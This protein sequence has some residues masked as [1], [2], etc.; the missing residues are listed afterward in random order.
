MNGMDFECHYDDEE[1]YYEV[2]VNEEYGR[3][4]PDESLHPKVGDKFVIYGWDATKIG[5]TGLI[6]AAEE[7]LYQFIMKKLQELKI[8]PN[9]YNCSMKSD[10]YE[11]QMETNALKI[12]SLGQKVRLI[13]PTYFS[14]GRSSRIIGYEVKLDYIYDSPMYIVGE[15]L[16]YSRSK[17]I[18]EQI[19]A[20]TYNGS[21]YSGSGSGGSGVYIITNTSQTPASDYNVFSALRSLKEFVSKKKDDIAEGLLGLR[22]GVWFGSRFWHINGEGNARLNDVDANNLHVNNDARFD[23]G[24]TVGNFTGVSGG[25]LTIDEF[26][27]SYGE[28][29]RLKVRMKAYFESL[30]TQ[31]V[32]TVGGKV[33]ISPAGAATIAFVD[34]HRIV[35]VENEGGSEEVDNGIPEG[36][37][38]CYFIGEQDGVTL[39]NLWK[40]GDQ[41]MSKTFNISTGVH[42][43]VSNHYYWRLVTAISDESTMLERNGLKYHW[44]DL[45]KYDCDTGS[46]IPVAT[47]VVAQVGNRT[48][49]TRQNALIFSSVDIYSPSVTLCHGIDSYTFLNKEYVEYGVNKST[50]KAFFNVFGDF[51]TGD[52][53]DGNEKEYVKY[54]NGK[55][56]IAG[57]LRIGNKST[58]DGTPIDQYIKDNG[59]LTEEEVKTLIGKDIDKIQNQID[60]AI[61]TWFYSGEP[62]LINSPA[63]GW[64]NDDIKDVH[65][66]DLYY[67]KETGYGYR[68]MY[69]DTEDKYLWY[70]ITD[71]DIIKA[72]DNAAKAQGTADSKMKV[73]SRQPIDSESYDVGDLWVNATYPSDGS[74]YK[75]DIL[76][77]SVKKDAGVAFNIQHWGK[78]SKY[79]D[80]TKALQALNEI[81]ET[82]QS[83]G[84][85]E[86]GVN[87]FKTDFDN[88]AADGVFTSAEVAALQEDARYIETIFQGAKGS[89]DKVISNNLL[90]D[91]GKDSTEKI[92]LTTAYN[93]LQKAKTD[94]VNIIHNAVADYKADNF[95]ITAVSSRYNNFNDAYNSF[96][97]A[98]N[99]AERYITDKSITSTYEGLD[100]RLTKLAKNFD[101]EIQ[102]GLILSSMLALRGAD[103]KTINAGINGVQKTATDIATWWGGAMKDRQQPDNTFSQDGA[104]SLIRF[105]GSGYFANGAI[106]WN[107]IGQLH[108]DPLSFF[109]GDNYVGLNLALFQFVPNNATRIEDVSHVIPQAPFKSLNVIDYIAIGKIKLSWDA[110]NNALKIESTEDGGTANLYAT[111]GVSALGMS[112]G[113]TGGGAGASSLSELLDVSVGNQTHG[114]VLGWDG[115]GHWVPMTVQ[116]GLD[117][118]ALANYLSTNKYIKDGDNISRLNNNAGYITSSALSG[119]ATQSW[120]EEK[121]YLTAHQSIS[122]L[123]KIDGSNGT[124]EGL[125]AMINKLNI[126]DSIPVDNDYF[127]SQYVNGGTTT[128]TYYRRKISTLWSYIK[129]KSDAIYQPKGSYLTSHQA[130]DYINVKDIRN[131]D[132]LP[133]SFASRKLT[134]WFNN[135]NVPYIG[136]WWSGITVKGWESNYASWQLASNAVYNTNEKNLYFRTGINSEWNSWQKVLTSFNTKIEDGVI[137]ING[138]SITPLTSHQ[139]LANYV[140]RSTNQDIS[141]YKTFLNPTKHTKEMFFK[142]NGGNNGIYFHSLADGGL[143]IYAHTNYSWI[144]NLG[145][146]DW[147]GNIKMNSFIKSGGTAHQFLKAD[148]SVDSAAYIAPKFLFTKG[149]FQHYMVLLWKE[150][151]VNFHRINGKIYTQTN[152]AI[153][154]QAAN[155]DMWYSRW[156][157]GF[158]YNLRLDTFGLGIKWQLVTCTYNGE[159]WYA[160]R[161]ANTQAV[162]AYFVGTSYNINFTAIHYYTSN[163]ATVVNTEINSSIVDKTSLLSKPY[164]G[165]NA[166]ALVS[167]NVASASM[168]ANTRIIWGQNF[169]GTQNVTGNMTSVGD[170]TT[171]EA[172]GRKITCNG[173]DHTW[174]LYM[175]SGGENRG[176][177]EFTTGYDKWLLY[178]NN[179]NTILNHGNVGVGITPTEKLHVNGTIKTTS[180]KLAQYLF[181]HTTS[182]NDGTY[183]T[184]GSTG[185]NLNTHTGFSYTNNIMTWLNTGNVG[186]GNGAPSYKLDVNGDTIVR[187]W[188]RTTGQRGWYSQDYGGGWYMTDSTWLRNYGSKPLNIATGLQTDGYIRHGLD[189]NVLI[190]INGIQTKAGKTLSLNNGN[191]TIVWDSTNNAYKINGNLYATGGISALGAN[192]ITSAGIEVS[193]IDIKNT[194][195]ATYNIYRQ[196]HNLVIE[197]PYNMGY[198]TFASDVKFDGIIS[199]GDGELDVENQTLSIA[200]VDCSSLYCSQLSI[201]NARFTISGNEIY[202]QIGSNKYKLTKTTA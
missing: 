198:I 91:D 123:L 39:E 79:T 118:N 69:D 139:S 163:T 103:G 192:F 129:G 80:D 126:G 70:R 151:E 146:I 95:E 50:D 15:S 17:N 6:D 7:E 154:Y 25:A 21:N 116:G 141:G 179:S 143:N 68:F 51:Y 23:K 14:N 8:D 54:E 37:Y 33:V 176:I 197:D 36:V 48:D 34:E 92:N 122:H 57:T 131:T 67:D 164:I 90:L 82:R 81:N 133:N 183:L 148:G 113:G 165:T 187:G 195:Y 111:G 16:V 24:L 170:I 193:A 71:N 184:Q 44:I 89:Y 1:K 86:D 76:R 3:M 191:N 83:L 127:I 125:S 74:T 156:S 173:T 158:D 29:D 135:T 181:F 64:T 58:I 55:V 5:N 175:G 66:G 105:D 63:S 159:T 30:E 120:V 62:T 46:D 128:T 97:Q 94:L 99:I 72:L 27:R 130:L 155:I 20:I 134:A 132:M 168:L 112:Q 110:A 177:Y 101:T 31:E 145:N 73:F 9:T 53:R 11:E 85:L 157:S 140:D 202:V 178:F 161:F 75:N 2:V 142:N 196:N 32:N 200:S 108:A 40:S 77:T 98:L 199:F 102:G 147:N 38:R 185:L 42:H 96:Y 166:Y 152:G 84:S 182:G 43:G 107:K 186:I 194:G 144:K 172:N 121:N 188:L 100:S 93:Q 138:T 149:D 104:I 160:L 136:Y 35:M 49:K 119:Y 56:D 137:T 19:D 78:A 26:G 106:W 189:G 60:G 153:R 169:N 4:L 180:L 162:N 124:F 171:I 201:G 12:Y 45:S 41:A 167:D 117:Q 22:K 109:V 114:Q 13:N 59:G 87:K 18:Q 47:D 115:S 150:S 28:V 190:N 65:L 61:E 10:W 88:F 52:R 174:G